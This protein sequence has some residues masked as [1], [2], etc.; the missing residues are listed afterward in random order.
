MKKFTYKY[1]YFKGNFMSNSN[2]GKNKGSV[3]E[4]FESGT[5]VIDPFDLEDFCEINSDFCLTKIL[6]HKISA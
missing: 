6:E 3:I 5:H 4:T 1:I 2:M